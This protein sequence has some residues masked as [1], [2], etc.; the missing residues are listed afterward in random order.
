VEAAYKNGLINGKTATTYSPDSNM[1]YAEA[2]KLAAC[3]HQLYHDGVVTLTNGEPYWYTDYL[4]YALMNNIISEL[5]DDY[6]AKA[7]REEFVHIFYGALPA[8]EYGEINVVA[9][10]SIPDVPMSGN[11]AAEIYAFYRAG[12]L[13]GSDSAG[14]FSPLSN[15]RRSEVAAILTRMFD[16]S[17]RK[18]ITLW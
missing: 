6:D 12:I 15:I 7:T 17:A 10:G 11:H 9:D 5:Y 4:T 13:T 18:T 2:I 14:T 16:A 8:A 1:T 3:M